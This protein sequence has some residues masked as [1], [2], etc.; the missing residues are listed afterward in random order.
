M[1]RPKGSKNRPKLTKNCLTCNK[2]IY[3]YNKNQKYCSSKECCS[4][5]RMNGK[6]I[7]C[8]QCGNEVYKSKNKLQRHKNH[9]CS[10]ICS[11]KFQCRNKIKLVCEYCK[12]E[13][14]RS[15]SLVFYNRSNGPNRYKHDYCSYNCRNKCP[16]YLDGL[17]KLRIKQNKSKKPTSIEVLGAKILDS[18][19]VKYEQQKSIND[20][21]TVDVYIKDF[22]TVIQFD[23]SY[24][25]GH[26]SKIRNGIIDKRQKF[27]IAR[28]IS[29]DEYMKKCGIHVIRFWDFEINKE[30][31]TKKLTESGIL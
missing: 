5:G 31:V 27:R 18:L 26:P 17:L 15:K 10:L 13:F 7:K 9:F 4:K 28:D 14:L 12:K 29:Q 2:T 22:N 20:K 1:S 25:H 19:G 16:I 23:G 11:E 8:E 30:N 3:T 6:L 21:F 24:W